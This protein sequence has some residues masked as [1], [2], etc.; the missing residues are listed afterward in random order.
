[1]EAKRP[2][3]VP[4][5]A[6][7]AQ[8]MKGDRERCIE[9][10]MDDYLTKPVRAAQLYETISKV[11]VRSRENGRPPAL[12]PQEASPCQCTGPLPDRSDRIRAGTNANG[13][14]RA[15]VAGLKAVDGDA[16]LLVGIAQAFLEESPKLISEIEGAIAR[17]DAPLLHR[18]AHTI[19]GGL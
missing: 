10:G 1:R 12:K 8:A 16:A 17:D 14:T 4:I 7:T 2:E 5:V 15:M 13:A 3:R 6:M 11:V 19:K 9:A 18:A